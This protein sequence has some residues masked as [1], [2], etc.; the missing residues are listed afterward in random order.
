AP[1]F[2][3]DRRT[4][5]VVNLSYVLQFITPAVQRRVLAKVVEMVRPGGLLFIGA[6]YEV[7]GQVGEMPH[8][9]YIEWRIERGYSREEIEAKT[10]ALA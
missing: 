8:R 2:F 7:L 1:T 3:H 6:K 4:Y 5:D 9:Q 10:K